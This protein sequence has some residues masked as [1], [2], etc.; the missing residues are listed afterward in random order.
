[1]PEHQQYSAA[2]RWQAPHRHACANRHTTNKQRNTEEAVRLTTKME[3]KLV[4]VINKES[5]A[6]Y[7]SDFFE[8]SKSIDSLYRPPELQT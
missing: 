7:L 4:T 1:M 6:A 8:V 2:R 5:H 3:M